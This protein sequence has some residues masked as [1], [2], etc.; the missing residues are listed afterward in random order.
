MKRI[1][2]TLNKGYNIVDWLWYCEIKWGIRILENE[3]N[4]YKK[5]HAKKINTHLSEMEIK[6]DLMY[7]RLVWVK[8]FD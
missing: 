2:S 6:I 5:W 8:E 7:I 3:N 1:Y 4:Y